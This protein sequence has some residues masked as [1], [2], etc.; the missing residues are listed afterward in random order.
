MRK[1][2]AFLAVVAVTACDSRVGSSFVVPLPSIVGTFKLRTFNGK[3]PPTTV[4]QNATSTL[5]LDGDTLMFDSQSKV[6]RAT[7]TTITTPPAAP[8][9]RLT[10]V[11]GNY[12]LTSGVLTL[13]LPS[14]AGFTTITGTFSGSTVTLNDGGDIWIYSK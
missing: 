1:L 8:A 10:V 14:G 4:D 12:S 2:L 3:A 6:R 13:T 11:N 9:P 5:T 7:A